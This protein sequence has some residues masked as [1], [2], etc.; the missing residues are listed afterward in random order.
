MINKLHNIVMNYLPFV[1]ASILSSVDV[2][3]FGLVKEVDMKELNPYFVVI[4]MLLY[5][6]QPL[7]LWKALQ[8]ETLTIVNIMWNIISSIFIAILGLGLF[9]EKLSYREQIG[10]VLGFLTIYLFAFSNETDPLIR[11]F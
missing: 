6:I 2:L 7:I 4:A 9:H 8:Y 5:A 10:C 1:F 11:L 3:A